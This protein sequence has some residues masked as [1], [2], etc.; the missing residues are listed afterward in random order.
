M[1]MTEF[2][3]LCFIGSA[4]FWGVQRLLNF[5]WDVFVLAPLHCMSKGLYLIAVKSYRYLKASR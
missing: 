5:S 2:I 4:I 1:G 3:V